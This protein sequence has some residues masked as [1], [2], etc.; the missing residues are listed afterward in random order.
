MYEFTNDCL[1]NID[2]IDDEHRLVFLIVEGIS[3]QN[4][5]NWRESHKQMIEYHHDKVSENFLWWVAQWVKNM[6]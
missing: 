5:Y 3:T 1:L 6:T 4:F 2:T